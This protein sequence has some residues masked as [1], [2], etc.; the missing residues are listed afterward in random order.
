MTKG[1]S[2]HHEACLDIF[3]HVAKID[4]GVVTAYLI[5]KWYGIYYE[6]VKFKPKKGQWSLYVEAR[7]WNNE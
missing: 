4:K 1:Y 2:Y 3:I 6:T 7:N 5:S